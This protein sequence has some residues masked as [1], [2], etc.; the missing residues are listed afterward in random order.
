M[1][2]EAGA[3]S[4]RFDHPE[5]GRL[6]EE[7]ASEPLPGVVVLTSRFPLPTLEHLQR[8]LG[9]RV[10]LETVA[11]AGHA[12]LPEQPAATAD[13]MLRFIATLGR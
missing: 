9:P 1:Q 8:E 13:A 2:H 10:S 5:L 12:L 6:L 3:W 4:G 7:L 11:R